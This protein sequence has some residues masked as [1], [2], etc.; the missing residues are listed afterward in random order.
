[1]SNRIRTTFSVQHFRHKL[2]ELTMESVVLYT[3]TFVLVIFAL[4]PLVYLINSAFKP[5]DE[6][7]RFPPRFF[8][9]KPTM[10]N[11]S[12]LV[13]S[14][15]SSTV[16]FLR[17]VFNSLVTTIAT[18]AG[19]VLVCVLGAYGLVIHNPKGSGVIMQVVVAALMF[20]IY[21][22]QIPNY[23]VVTGLGMYDSFAALVVPK[24]AVAYNFFL[25]ERFTREIPNALIEAARIDGAGETHICFK[26]VM[27]LLKPAIAT[28]IVLTFISSWNDSFSP[29]VFLVSQE[30]KTL[31]VALSTIAGGVGVSDLGRV[32]ATMA[33]SLIT[34]LPTI[35]VFTAMQSKVMQTMAHSGIK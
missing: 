17:Y 21:V 2:H 3:F 9:R 13:V 19:T 31:P 11:F 33:A 1:M 7:L 24:I 30:K 28:L 6:I 23:M 18:V 25:M 32:G 27:P 35:V 20:S 16:P 12:N 10:D 14:L 15:S 5:L 29:L 26:V 4:L 34:A 8:V 22:T